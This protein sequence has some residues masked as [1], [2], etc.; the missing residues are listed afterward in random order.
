MAPSVTVNVFR[1]SALTFGIIYGFVHRKSLKSKNDR[2]H[3]LAEIKKREQWIDQAR[4]E[5]QLKQQILRS[6]GNNA[7]TDPNHPSFDLE[8]YLNQLATSSP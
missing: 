3:Y 7:I 5:W 6:G 1:Y 8:A 4:K 2:Q